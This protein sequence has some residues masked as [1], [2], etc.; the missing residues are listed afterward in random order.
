MPSPHPLDRLVARDSFA[1]IMAL[2]EPEELIIATL[3]LEELTDAQI[4]EILGIPRGAVNQRMHQASQRIM[5]QRPDLGDLLAG[6]RP[7]GASATRAPRPLEQGYICRWAEQ[8]SRLPELEIDLTI[9]EVARR[10]DVSPQ[11]VGR[12]VRAG[13]FSHAYRLDGEQGG[14]RIPE[15]DLEGFCPLSQGRGGRES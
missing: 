4:G 2:L 8:D 9:R 3:R 12:W 6:R 7:R 5:Q 11:A 13:Y 15:R 14:Y 1:E 10:F